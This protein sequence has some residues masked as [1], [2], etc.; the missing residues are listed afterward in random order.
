MEWKNLQQNLCPKCESELCPDPD[1]DRTL[2]TGCTFMMGLPKLRKTLDDMDFQT[3]TEMD[4]QRGL[5][6]L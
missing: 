5:S 1:K 2:C 3:H 4:N 6:E